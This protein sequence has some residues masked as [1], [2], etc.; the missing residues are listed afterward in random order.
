MAGL[1][2]ALEHK[3]LLETTTVFVTGEFGRTPK[4]NDRGGR[5]HHP[6]AMCVLMGG[7]GIRGGQV[8]GASDDKGM[9]PA[10]GDGITPDDIAATFYH[11]LGIDPQKEYRTTTGRP[12]A[13]VRYGTPIKD[14]L[15]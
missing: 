8:V 6:R 12:I 3:G 2:A 5:D 4:I 9:G 7:G 1:F 11:T 13:I 14:L 15:A 10:S